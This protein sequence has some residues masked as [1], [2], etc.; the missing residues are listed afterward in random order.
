[1][2]KNDWKDG[3]HEV[4]YYHHTDDGLII[5]QI[6]KITHTKVWI[7]KILDANTERILGQYIGYEYAKSAVERYWEIQSRTLLENQ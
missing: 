5:G 3:D 7:A 2:M 1:M 6:H 4:Y